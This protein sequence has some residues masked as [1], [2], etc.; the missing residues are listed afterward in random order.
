V[1]HR[2]P[3]CKPIAD[4]RRASLFADEALPIA[5]PPRWGDEVGGPCSYRIDV[6]SEAVN[7]ASVPRAVVE[8]LLASF[9]LRSA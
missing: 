6:E 3:D 9:A 4:K 7:E 8:R 2:L 1:L 5:E